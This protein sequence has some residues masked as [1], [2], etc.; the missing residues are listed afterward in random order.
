[1]NNDITS[2]NEP[3]AWKTLDST[4]LFQRPWLTLRQDRVQ[5]GNGHVIDDYYIQEYP[6]WV[7]V[8]AITAGQREAVL[9]RQYRHGIGEVYFELPAGVHD[10]DGETILQAAQRELFEETGYIGGTW[11]LWMELSANPALQTNISYTFL[12]ENVVAS[13]K[14]DLEETEEISVHPVSVEEL[15]QIALDGGMLQALHIAPILKYLMLH[16]AV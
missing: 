14:R 8:L 15:R 6:P 4:Y 12:A 16:H 1:M 13:G 9:I 11:T 2:G 10:R 5:L 7:N 3:A